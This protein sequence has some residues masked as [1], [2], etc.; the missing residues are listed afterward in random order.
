MKGKEVPIPG[1]VEYGGFTYVLSNFPLKE[2]DWYIDHQKYNWNV[3]NPVEDCVSKSLA[4]FIN[5]E[6]EDP[7]SWHS[8]KIVASDDPVLNYYGIKNL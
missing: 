7:K 1:I 5:K 6:N 2:G 4:R 3:G 8:K